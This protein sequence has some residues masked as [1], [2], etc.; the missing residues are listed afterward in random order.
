MKE[1]IDIKEMINARKVRGMNL[2]EQGIE[3]KEINSKTWIIPSQS[4]NGTYTVHYE[5]VPHIHWSCTCKDFELRGIPCKHINAVKIWKNLKDRFEQLHLNVKQHITSK[6]SEIQECKFCH[7]T[8]FIR[9]GLKNSKQVYKCKNCNRKF[10]DNVDFENMKYNPKIIALTLDLYFRGLS[11]RKVCQHLKEFYELDVSYTSV[12][13]WIEKYIGIM[14]DYVNSLQPDIGG[15][16]HNDEMMVNVGGNWE[17]LWNCMDEKTRFQ[18]ASVVSKE[19][20][21]RD[22]QVVF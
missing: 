1:H 19:K 13:R 16:W 7:S 17:F 5:Y 6:D 11:L 15:V 22:A 21:V 14:N 10:V 20:Q 18:L 3:P 9:Y 2:L 12:Y 4:G 8:N